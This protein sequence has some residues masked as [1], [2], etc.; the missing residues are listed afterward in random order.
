M[1]LLI[2]NKEEDLCLR[3]RLKGES[4]LNKLPVA[5]CY[6]VKY[7]SGSGRIHTIFPDLD[8]LFPK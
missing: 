3:V 2:K 8:P 5:S 1:V 6:R 7:K 4:N